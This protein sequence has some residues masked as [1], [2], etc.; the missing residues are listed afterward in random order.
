VSLTTGRLR[1]CVGSVKGFNRVQ[2]QGFRVT[3]QVNLGLTDV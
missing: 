3:A 1:V 2:W